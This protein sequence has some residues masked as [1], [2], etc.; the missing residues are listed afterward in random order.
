MFALAIWDDA[1]AALVL[2]R[3][4]F[5]EKP[6]YYGRVGRRPLV[7]ASEIKAVFGH[8]GRSRAADEE[9]VAL[10]LAR[11]AMPRTGRSFFAGVERLPAAHLLEWQDGRTAVRRYWQPALVDVPSRYEDA[12]EALR[13]LLTD[14]IRLRLRSDVPVGTS[15]SGGIDSSTVV[16]L[17][18][19][20]AGDHTRHAFTATFPGWERDEWG[21]ASVVAQR[22]GV[23]EHHGVA[24]TAT[25]AAADLDQFVL[26]HEEPVGS[27]SIYAQWR[28]MQE[29]KRAGVTVLLDGQGG[30]ELFA[31]YIPSSGFALRELGPRDAF[32][33]VRGDAGVLRRAGV[34]LAIDR[35]PGRLRR[36]ARRRAA[37]PYANDGVVALSTRSDPSD[38]VPWLEERR[39]L[40]RQLLVQSFETSL[41]QLLRY[42][43]R[44]SMAW[45][46]EV[47]LP[48][49]D[50]RVAEFALS[51]PASSVYRDG[52]LK[53]I[54]RDVG[55]GLVPDE[56]LDRADKVGFEPPQKRWL[57]EPAMRNRIAEVLLDPTAR[58]RGLYRTDA[59]ERDL[60]AGEWRDKD[61]IWRALNIELWFRLL[62][63]PNAAYA[64][65]ESITAASRAATAS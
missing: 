42:A 46:R 55:R 37:T 40:R 33:E 60:Q 24:P 43:D 51:L 28:V 36:L 64:A 45:S 44:S 12:V 19:A 53:R 65:N 1:G 30:D 9:A 29:A 27:L 59:L 38:G 14:S 23:V 15:L 2:A 17:S 34:A 32:A 31:G 52:V 50:P 49:L 3:D 10:F 63:E 20:L 13:E 39:P 56:V 57:A 21:Y 25:E 7:F 62:V 11:S 35:L 18:A 58:A 5:G 61:G 6:L 48:F 26:D 22:A 4:R 54:V 8:P 41:P 47:R 16:M